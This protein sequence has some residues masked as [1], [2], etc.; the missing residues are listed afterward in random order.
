VLL[1]RAILHTSLTKHSSPAI[2]HHVQ[3]VPSRYRDRS[4]WWPEDL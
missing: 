4:S 3:A 2:F 1:A